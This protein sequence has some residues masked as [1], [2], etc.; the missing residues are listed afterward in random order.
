MSLR[1]DIE[2]ERKC[3]G[4][5]KDSFCEVSHY[6]YNEILKTIWKKFTSLGHKAEEC[7]WIN[8]NLS[9][10][11]VGYQPKNQQTV[12]KILSD[13][14]AKDSKIWFVGQ[15]GKTGKNSKPKY[16]LYESDICSSLKILDELYCFDFYIVDKK[17]KWLISEEHHGVL[18]A[19]GEPVASHLESYLHQR[20]NK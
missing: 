16:W 4:I 20:C 18:V 17:Y 15:D 19:S 1:N 2:I 8:H 9:G 14:L 6:K 5:S 11:V 12:T 7:S 13:I 3:F 10:S